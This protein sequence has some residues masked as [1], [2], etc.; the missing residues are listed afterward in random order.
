ML[1]EGT[2]VNITRTMGL[3]IALIFSVVLLPTVVD[4]IGDVNTTGWNFTGVEGA[5]VLMN[6]IPFIFIAGLVIAVV[7][8]LLGK[9]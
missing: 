2:G 3:V 9:V 1:K 5:I 8:S 7:L 4:T 6:L